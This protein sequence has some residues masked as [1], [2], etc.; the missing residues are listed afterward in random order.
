MQFLRFVALL[1]LTF[2]TAAYAVDEP[3]ADWAPN[4]DSDSPEGVDNPGA[5]ASPDGT[6]EIT[7]NGLTFDVTGT[8]TGGVVAVPSSPRAVVT[9]ALSQLSG[10]AGA[11]TL[12]PPDTFQMAR[13]SDTVWTQPGQIQLACIPPTTP[14]T[15]LLV[16]SQVPKFA[17][18]RTIKTWWDVS[19]PP[20]GAPEWSSV[21]NNGTAINLSTTVGTPT[22]STVTVTNSG[23]SDLTVNPT[24][25]SGALSVSG[26]GSTATIAAGGN[27]G[28][29]VT[30]NPASASTSNQTLSFDTN[31]GTGGED[32]VTFPVQCIGTAAAA[33]DYASTPV[34]GA[35]ISLTSQVGNPTTSNLNISN[36]GTATLT[37]TLAGLSGVLGVSS[38]SL[39]LAG[40]ANQ[41]Y[42]IT[43][44]PAAATTVV[45][46]LT[47]TSNDA[48]ES[49]A[50]YTVQCTGSS[51]PAPEFSSSPVGGSTIAITAAV[52]SSN[53]GL[54]TVTNSGNAN[55]T[56]TAS[57]GGGP[58]FSVTPATLQTI[59][60]PPGANTRVFT[61]TC[62][63]TVAGTQTQTLTLA[64][65]DSDE[66]SVTY[67]VNCTG[68]A[69]EFASTPASP[70]PI[71]LTATQGG[72][73]PTATITVNNTGDLP[74]TVADSGLSGRLSISATGPIAPGGNAVLTITCTTATAGSVAQTLTLTTNDP[75]E[76]SV[77]FNV[78]CDVGGSAADEFFSSPAPGAVAIATT[79]GVTG[80]ATILV[81]NVG[82]AALTGVAASLTGAP[83]EITSPSLPGPTS[84]AAGA[85]QI[86]TINCVSAVAG[87]PF[88][89]TFTIV[90]SDGPESPANYNV[91][92]NVA[93]SVPDYGSTPTPG[94]TI[95]LSAVVGGNATS[96]VTARNV[97]G[98]TLNVSAAIPGGPVFAVAPAGPTAIAAGG[99]QA[100]TLTCTPTS[101]TTQTQ[102]LTVST[103]ETG[104]NS[105]TYTVTCTG[106]APS[107]GEFDPSVPNGGTIT[108]NTTRGSSAASVLTITNSAASNLTLSNVALT[109]GTVITLG[110]LTLPIT[111]NP[112]LTRNINL[113][114]LSP[115]PG[116]FNDTLTFTTSDVDE[117]TVT[118][119]ITC[120][121]ADIPPDFN[122]LQNP[123]TTITI[124]ALFGSPSTT[125]ITVQNTAA[126]SGGTLNVTSGGL[127]SP[128]SITSPAGGG[129][130][131]APG[132]SQ[133]F[134]VQC[135]P[136]VVF[137]GF[138]PF[139]VFQ[140][141]TF[142]QQLTFVSDDPDESPVNFTV[143]CVS[144]FAPQPEFSSAPDPGQTI[145]LNT[146]PNVA[147]T[148]V[149]R[150]SNAGSI[151]DSVAPSLAGSA[152]ISVAP[153]VA[154]P[155][156]PGGSADFVVTCL[157][158]AVGITASVLTLTSADPD[159][160]TNTYNVI[161]AAG[162]PPEPELVSF[163]ASG[164]PINLTGVSGNQVTA[165][166]GVTNI[167]NFALRLLSCS[168]TGRVFSLPPTVNPLIDIAP[169]DSTVVTVV[170]DVPPVGVPATGTLSCQ[171]SDSDEPVII[172]PLACS[173]ST[174]PPSTVPGPRGPWLVA[175]ALAF[176]ALAGPFLVRRRVRIRGRS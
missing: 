92:C 84:L 46:T 5:V 132:G 154:T 21:P 83:A 82:G 155:I 16:C 12:V 114:C 161:C 160:I 159:E 26:S 142:T 30:C 102:T 148:S 94:A 25:L 158:T 157:P 15:G 175:L 174:L 2:T 108:I 29:T 171:T 47:V 88:T 138:P 113:A 137:V 62:A 86:Y 134:T 97:G 169:A 17:P 165:S 99:S 36:T 77:P 69:P 48:D 93:N 57:I 152:T 115:T 147:T 150:A 3:V 110:A 19:C 65:N 37:G 32:P 121:V 75:D 34:D 35:T 33:P 101:T 167:G 72:A 149:V 54:V 22:T 74:L 146:L 133:N 163:P 41:N 9:C 106:L 176:L 42:T 156:V 81:Q 79:P 27:Q 95:A 100:L 44:T 6:P 91:T 162:A 126:A 78:G 111:I 40:G 64:T 125:N 31:D 120:V 55:L 136:T 123:A 61:V 129:A 153:A 145:V 135:F 43:C 4:P 96:V 127:F 131:I 52:G 56:A 51:A 24:G 103:D 13:L 20:V 170:C 14:V 128:L 60:P 59:V 38:P 66:G 172:F 50:T 76:A 71:T 7:I 87:G 104:T 166:I 122:S 107:G 118:Y 1:L 173:G 73:A 141:G 98:G 139:P 68:Q 18:G 45:Q 8:P 58:V 90:H 63:P 80:T 39:N 11:L 130:A 85:S 119:A 140:I 164:F 144:G 28:F 67:S 105:Y 116:V 168:T 89:A 53:T 143:S 124:N 117:T 151:P 109:T 10:P 70:G 49:P 112:S 23:L